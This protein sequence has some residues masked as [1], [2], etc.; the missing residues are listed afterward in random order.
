MESIEIEP[1]SMRRAKSLSASAM[2]FGPYLRSKARFDRRRGNGRCNDTSDMA[3]EDQ[4]A[5]PR[6]AY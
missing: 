3:G 6:P 1:H 4:T 5:G 2:S